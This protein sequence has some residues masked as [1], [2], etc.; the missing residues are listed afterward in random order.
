MNANLDKLCMHLTN[1]AINKHNRNFVF[2]TSA[3]NMGVGH[4]RSLTCVFKQLADKGLDVDLLKEKIKDRIIKTVISGLPLMSH[5]YK[6][7]QP[8]DYSGNM[9][10]HIL[11]L[12]VMIN[13]KGDP[14]I[15]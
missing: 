10:F 8:E 9:C 15:I 3:N 14:Y 1:Y 5:Q 12:D 4:K 13:N 11:G 6:F 7:S 2:N